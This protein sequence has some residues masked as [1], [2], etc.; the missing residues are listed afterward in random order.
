V[1]ASSA[2]GFVKAAGSPQTGGVAFIPRILAVRHPS[3]IAAPRV[4]IL[5]ADIG[6]GHDLPAQLLS[7][8]L[9]AAE[10]GTVVMVADAL[11]NMGRIPYALGRAGAESI[12]ERTPRLFDAQFRLVQGFGPTR[13]LAARLLELVAGERIAELIEHSGPDV[14]VSTYP[15]T[16]ELLGRLRAA[17][18]VGVPCVAAITDLAALGWWAHPGIDVHLII[19]EQSRAEVEEI[20]GP[21]ADIRHVRGMSRPEFTSPPSR[22]A[23]RAALGLPAS[24]PVVVVSGGGWGVG[25]VERAARTVL[26]IPGATAVCLCGTNAG[27]RERLEAD[28]ADEPRLR[29][30]GF[31]DRMAD[32]LAAAD[33]LVH[34]TAGL[35]VLEAEMCGTWAISYGWGVGHIRINNAAYRRFGL[36]AVAANERELAAELRTAL[37]APRPRDGGFA[38]LPQAADVIRELT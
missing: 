10:P 37:A 33:V 27:L 26:A 38:E 4:L 7:D 29:A 5:T 3:A 1:S 9:L 2:G 30:E 22:E 14:V 32:W 31:T 34:S 16:T 21:G 15:G 25:D 28:F 36:A 6:A 19:H 35:T 8:A 11:R 20:A 17:G 13:R 12:L 18:R 24:G 23:A